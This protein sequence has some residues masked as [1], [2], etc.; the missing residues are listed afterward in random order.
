MKDAANYVTLNIAHHII[1]WAIARIRSGS[2]TP[3]QFAESQTTNAHPRDPKRATLTL[4][5]RQI[6]HE[7]PEN[8]PETLR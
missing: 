6:M 1:K 2:M 7:K 3:E 4:G 5:I 8:L